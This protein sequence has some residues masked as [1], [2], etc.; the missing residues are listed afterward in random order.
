MLLVPPLDGGS[1]L[2]FPNQSILGEGALFFPL[3]FI[4]IAEFFFPPRV[5]LFP[6]SM[7]GSDGF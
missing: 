4:E 5:Q 2:S 6:M 1:F 7:P 3:G